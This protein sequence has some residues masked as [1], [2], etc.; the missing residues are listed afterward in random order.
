MKE[1]SDATR[2]LVTA[3]ELAQ[4]LSISTRTI[5]RLVRLGVIT[6]VQI[7]PYCLRYDVEGVIQ[8]LKDRGKAMS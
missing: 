3:T 7:T 8:A 5:A 2:R 1:D 6:P 4:S